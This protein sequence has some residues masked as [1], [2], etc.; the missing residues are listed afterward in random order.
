VDVSRSKEILKSATDLVGCSTYLDL[1]GSL[2]DGKQ[3]H[4]SD[5]REE[6]TR[7]RMALDLA[8]EGRSVVVVSSG[9]PG[10]YAMASAVFEVLEH[11]ASPEWKILVFT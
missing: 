5:N 11:D 7:A 4:A 8:A 1:V 10:I 6:L 9:D 3:R 2:G